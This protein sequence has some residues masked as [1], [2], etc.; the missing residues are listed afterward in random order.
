[1]VQ[2]TKIGRQIMCPTVS[3]AR[4]SNALLGGLHYQYYRV[5]G[6]RHTQLAS[7]ALAISLIRS[8]RAALIPSMRDPFTTALSMGASSPIDKVHCHSS[9]P[10]RGLTE[11]FKSK[12]SYSDGILQTCPS[13]TDQPQF[14]R[15]AQLA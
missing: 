13:E 8:S 1:M 7:T 11:I 15:R 5:Y 3:G 14:I 10:P 6:L 4:T 12:G 2:A 9:M